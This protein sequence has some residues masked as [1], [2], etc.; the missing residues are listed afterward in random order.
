MQKFTL[1]YESHGTVKLGGWKKDVTSAL[2]TWRDLEISQYY[3]CHAM[4]YWLLAYGGSNKKLKCGKESIIFRSEVELI[5]FLQEYYPKLS[6]DA[7]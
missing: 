4:T 2:W 7:D 1:I 5:N 6:W 3:D